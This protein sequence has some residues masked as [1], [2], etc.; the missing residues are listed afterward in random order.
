MS[1][2]V[3]RTLSVKNALNQN[4]FG[5]FKNLQNLLKELFNDAKTIAGRRIDYQD[6][7]IEC[8]HYEDDPKT[9]GFLL[10]LVIYLPGDHASIVPD[11]ES[12][13]EYKIGLAPPPKGNNYFGGQL[14]LLI[15]QNNV[16]FC[17]N[18]SNENFLY[19]FVRG[20]AD[21]AKLDTTLTYFSLLKLANIDTI[22]QIK[23]RGGVKKVVLNAIAHSV[24]L[25]HID[26]TTATEKSI[27]DRFIGGVLEE[28]MRVTGL[29]PQTTQDQQRIENLKASVVFEFDKRKGTLLELE[30]ITKLAQS[31]LDEEEDG[32]VIEAMDGTKYRP[33]DVTL[34][35][36][37]NFKIDGGSAI[38]Y[39]QAWKELSNFYQTLQKPDDDPENS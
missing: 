32:F 36:P 1:K 28:A 2:I 14:I 34:S 29:D 3:K 7:R 38:D 25:G 24:S 26:R 39:R 12:S 16:V 8:A 4:D 22:K 20:M 31:T 21:K 9:G 37:C 5:S 10:H 30:E 35:K 11:E 23:Q 15:H 33:D 27:L 6:L 17:K 13:V 18:N 19:E